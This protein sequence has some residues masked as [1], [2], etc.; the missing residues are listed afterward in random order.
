MNKVEYYKSKIAEGF[1]GIRVCF[2]R[3]DIEGANTGVYRAS[4]FYGEKLANEIGP[5]EMREF[6][7]TLF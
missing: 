2:R 7:K 1:Q 6:L 5:E 3:G 4:V